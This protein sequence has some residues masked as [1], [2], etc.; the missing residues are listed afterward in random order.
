MGGEIVEQII[1][2]LLWLG[3]FNSRIPGEF[4][5]FDWFT[6]R[7]PSKAENGNVWCTSA[8]EIDFFMRLCLIALFSSLADCI[9]RS[10]SFMHTWFPRLLS[11]PL[12]WRSSL[13]LRL[14]FWLCGRTRGLKFLARSG[15]DYTCRQVILVSST[16]F[17]A[18]LRELTPLLLR[19]GRDWKMGETAVAYSGERAA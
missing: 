2:F 12:A 15:R 16:K 4:I 11:T 6:T 1:L 3:L 10:N 8:L 18:V 9:R 5:F 19:F 14:P 17:F 7:Q 13:G